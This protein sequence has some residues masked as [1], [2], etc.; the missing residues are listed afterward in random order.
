MRLFAFTTVLAIMLIGS[1]TWAQAQIE[2]TPE[3][4]SAEK[5]KNIRGSIIEPSKL[6]KIQVKMDC[7]NNEGMTIKP[8]E[9]GYEECMKQI[10][11]EG[12]SKD[13]K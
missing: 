1:L 11:Q 2:P 5:M 9:S 12:E 7:V 8:N 6:K 3:S 13:K 4:P 10:K